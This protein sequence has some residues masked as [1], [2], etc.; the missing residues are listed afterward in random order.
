MILANFEMMQYI[1]NYVPKMFF[2]A[3]T[4][5]K[6]KIAMNVVVMFT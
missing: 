5:D 2:N 4:P 3:E 6:L 1:A